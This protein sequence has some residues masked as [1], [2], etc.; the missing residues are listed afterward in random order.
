M[1]RSMWGRV[2]LWGC[3]FVFMFVFMIVLRV[4]RWC[5]CKQPE[6]NWAKRR[7][8]EANSAF[9]SMRIACRYSR[10]RE[11]VRGSESVCMRADLD[12][13]RLS[14]CIREMERGGVHERE[15][16]GLL[17]MRERVHAWVGGCTRKGCA[18]K[19]TSMRIVCHT[20]ERGSE[21]G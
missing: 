5:R 10:E 16:W 9:T 4:V 19:I 7:S 1:E 13:N 18:W 6:G 2:Y 8:K 20:I 21:R 12:A 14:L 11:R 17:C 15:D 3:K